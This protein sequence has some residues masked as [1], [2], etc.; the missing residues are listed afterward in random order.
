M[1][2]PIAWVSQGSPGTSQWE[3]EW[4][5]LMRAEKAFIYKLE[6]GLGRKIRGELS[7]KNYNMISQ[8]HGHP[9]NDD[10]FFRLAQD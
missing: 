2:K 4:T 10:S 9:K 3:N 6:A 8:L 7:R 5:D 1:K